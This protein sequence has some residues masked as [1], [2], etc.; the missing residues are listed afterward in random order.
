MIKILL[1]ESNNILK[2]HIIYIL[3]IVILIINY[4]IDSFEILKN[5]RDNY[6]L[7]TCH[8]KKIVL[9]QRFFPNIFT[10]RCNR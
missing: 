1:F 8:Y 5:I 7:P 10:N 6:T 3:K 4:E 2:R 9:S